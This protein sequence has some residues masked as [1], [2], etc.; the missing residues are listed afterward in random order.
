MNP[1][2]LESKLDSFDGK[3]RVEALQQ[4]KKNFPPAPGKNKGF[5]NL[6]CHTFYSFNGYGYSPEKVAW[7]AYKEGLA[8]AGSVDFDVLDAAEGMLAAGRLLGLRTVAGIETRVF[9]KDLASKVIN[10]PGEPG[11]YY[12][13]GTGFYKTPAAGSKSAKLLLKFAEIARERNLSRLARVN[14]ELPE[15]ALDYDKDVLPLTPKGNATERHILAAFIRK[16]EIIY[17]EKNKLAG[18]WAEKLDLTPDAAGALLA[19]PAELGELIRAKFFKKASDEN[20]NV[21]KNYPSLEE[22]MGMIKEEGALPAA[23]YLD[24]TSDGEKDIKGLLEYLLK[25]GIVL[26]NIIPDRNWNI[27]DPKA[28]EIKYANFRLAMQ[29]ARELKLPVIAGT[30]MNKAGLKQVDDFSV[31]DLKPYL[32]AFLNGA[33][34]VYGHTVLAKYFDKGFGGPWAE[35]CFPERS[36]RNEFYIKAGKKIDPAKD[37]SDVTDSIAANV[38]P[39]AVLALL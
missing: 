7:L 34:F 35:S 38:T 36:K 19:K 32:A 4:L 8:A 29:V 22:V 23:A 9:V 27:K 37:Y 24:G 20:E 17:K 11:V 5:V 3:E 12:F 30:E 10:S 39:E 15:V 13:M 14:S 1:A 26:L 18:Y 2:E 25:K 21:S 31:P 33:Y 6:H 16:A 28:K